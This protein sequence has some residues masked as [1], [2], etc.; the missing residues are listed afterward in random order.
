MVVSNHYQFQFSSQGLLNTT[1][2]EAFSYL[3]DPHK[4]SSH[5]SQ[6]SWMMAGSKMDMVLDDKNGMGV[7]AEIILKGKMMGIPLYVREFVTDSQDSKLKVWETQGPQKMIILEQYKMGFRL[8]PEAKKVRLT[9]FIE[10]NLP[11]RGIG[12]ALGKLL[13]KCY[14]KWC[15][16]QM[17]KSAL[18]H[19]N[20]SK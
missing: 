10:Y 15:T 13:G 6:S 4:L 8:E 11:A 9:V 5:M 2:Q 18:H 7:G 19:F 16:D 20:K 1:P 3:N 14:A 17:V 12:V